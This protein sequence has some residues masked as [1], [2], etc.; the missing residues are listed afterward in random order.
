[1]S[2]GYANKGLWLRGRVTWGVGGGFCAHC[3]TVAGAQLKMWYCAACQAVQYSS[4]ECQK[5]S[6]KGGHKEQ[7][8][9][10]QQGHSTGHATGGNE[11]NAFFSSAQLTLL[12]LC[13]VAKV[14]SL[15]KNGDIWVC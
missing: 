1:M 9:L 15:R 11:L 4:K 10:R 6:W 2:F 14:P 13:E 12:A 8:R 5:A 7:C 3:G